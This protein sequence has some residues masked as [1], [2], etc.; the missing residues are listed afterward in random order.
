MLF[1][2]T[3][4]LFV[5]FI[6]LLLFKLFVL[7][8]VVETEPD[9]EIILPNEIFFGVVCCGTGC[10]ISCLF[11]LFMYFLGRLFIYLR[12]IHLFVLYL[13]ICFFPNILSQQL[14]LVASLLVLVRVLVEV[15]FPN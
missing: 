4:T 8:G 6:L 2:G 1:L 13:C 12:F 7:T 15:P 11:C 10:C 5:V 3:T 14:F 9:F